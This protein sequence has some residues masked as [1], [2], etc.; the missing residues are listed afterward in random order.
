MIDTWIC[1]KRSIISQ[2]L[3]IVTYF[4]MFKK[5]MKCV[6]INA[7]AILMINIFTMM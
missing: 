1:R 3:F 2:K 7:D 5:T 6:L 4:H